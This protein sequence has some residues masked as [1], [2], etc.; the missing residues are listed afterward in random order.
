VTLYTASGAAVGTTTT[1]ANGNYRFDNLPPGDYVVEFS[2]LPPTF[3]A[4]SVNRGDD[5]ADSDADPITL[6]TPIISLSAGE[7][8]LT[9]DLGIVQ[10]RQGLPRTGGEIV[11]MLTVALVA[12][13]VGSALW[14]VARR[15]R[16]SGATS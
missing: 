13:L 9:W 1:D 7:V 16:H 10:A 2:N 4:T 11:R 5:G 3:G 15:R 8:D 14:V 12:V 6:R